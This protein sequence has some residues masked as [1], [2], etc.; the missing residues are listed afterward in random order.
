[1]KI[2]KEKVMIVG[3]VLLLFVAV[4]GI[5]YAAFSYSRKGS[6]VNTITTG[7]ITMSY[8]ESSN[9]ITIDRA[10]PTTD[11]TGKVQLRDGEYF[12]FTVSSTIQGT[13]NINWEIAA[14]DDENNTISGSNI[15]YYLTKVNV[16][17]TEE[18]VMAPS[19]YHEEVAANEYTGRPANMMS[20]YI[21]S[22]NAST[23][24]KYR[25]RL[26]VTEEYNPQGDGGG[27]IYK[28]RINVYGKT[29]EKIPTGSVMK[30][31]SNKVWNPISSEN[32]SIKEI[33]TKKDIMIP[34]TAIKNFD[35]SEAGD[36]SVIA[37][38]ENIGT[39]GVT[40]YRLTIGSKG[41]VIA[42]ADSSNLF[43]KFGNVTD[44]D[45]SNFDTSNVIDMKY[46]FYYC[47]A[48]TSLDLRNFDTAKATDMYFMFIGT[49]AMTQILVSNK[50]T[51]ANANTTGMFDRSGVSEVTYV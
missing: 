8:E 13:A 40:E 6:K 12:D 24:T 7:V 22:M 14:E 10:L 25:L 35:A 5:S 27:L 20:L 30:S 19:V 31:Y 49:T 15:K 33:V 50:W 26:Y 36:N 21:G 9:V 3:A 39:D 42:P 11:A 41:G 45:L 16:D 18:E 46:M 28:T 51:T 34:E 48:L 29:G 38:L 1:M 17:G 44:I 4:I 37:Y 23:T 2:N 43:Y 47:S 32:S